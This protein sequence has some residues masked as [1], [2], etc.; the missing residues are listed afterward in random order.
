MAEE[1]PPVDTAH[2]TDAVVENYR[3]RTLSADAVLTVSAHIA[4]CAPCRER[5]CAA[6]ALEESMTRLSAAVQSS[7][8]AED[9]HPDDELLIAFSDK[10]SEQK[11][12][13]I[14][15]E[16]VACHLEICPA[17]RFQAN[18]LRA[19]HALMTSAPSVAYAPSLPPS[20]WQR[21]L[22]W[23]QLP[24]V[25]QTLQ[26]SG[27]SL[28]AGLLVFI[29]VKRPAPSTLGENPSHAGD[30]R[31][32]QREMEV[33][34]QAAALEKREA[35]LARHEEQITA[36][37]TKLT[38]ARV[39]LELQKKR[40]GS[41]RNPL[42][43][44]LPKEAQLP[45][46][47]TEA[48]IGFQSF[49]GGT[50]TQDPFPFALLTPAPGAVVS[51]QQVAF[52]WKALRGAAG[53]KIKRYKI[54]LELDG[55]RTESP[56]LTR[57]AWVWKTPLQPGKHY[58]W[59]VLAYDDS[60]DPMLIAVSPTRQTTLQFSTLTR[61][62]LAQLKKA[63][64][65]PLQLGVFFAKAGMWKEAEQMFSASLLA[66]PDDA[67]VQKW[68]RQVCQQRT[69]WLRKVTARLDQIT[70]SQ[71]AGDMKAYFQLSQ[72]ENERE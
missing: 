9:D 3:A 56:F 38:G 61:V 16:M 42:P 29:W 41:A 13:P 22:L 40:L 44:Q 70:D 52:Q 31:Q 27:A 1:P 18:E 15:Q 37:Q 57:T 23:L 71:G 64:N 2:L 33:A 6:L 72:L 45:E 55:V 60:P 26:L 43:F 53:E 20:F 4:G 51:P 66:K 8:E 62:Q 10:N 69:T 39:A 5:L 65:S 58:S 14:E 25:R 30:L 63:S 32:K 59:K 35:S 54:E 19:L 68:L 36:E 50:Q 34:R 46:N 21:F 11:L 28:A 17:C 12:S 49:S 7:P 47:A 67:R 24:T 48:G